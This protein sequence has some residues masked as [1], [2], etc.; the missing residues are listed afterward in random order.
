M[1][2]FFRDTERLRINHHYWSEKCEAVD[3]TDGI[4]QYSPDKARRVVQELLDD[5]EASEGLRQAVKEEVLSQVEE[6][7]TFYKAAVNFE[8]DQHLFM[9]FW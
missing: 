1:F 9:D 3:R 8:N 4:K 5:A 2:E 6:S 7:H